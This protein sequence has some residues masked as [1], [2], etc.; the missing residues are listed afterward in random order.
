[1]MVIR[2]ALHAAV[3]AVLLVLVVAPRAEASAAEINADVYAA[4][5]QF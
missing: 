1:M 2:H 4:L 5:D 3:L